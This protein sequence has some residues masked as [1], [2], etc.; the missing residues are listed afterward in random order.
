MHERDLSSLVWIL[1]GAAVM[2]AA[3]LETWFKLL[4]PEKVLMAYG[5]T[6]NFGLTVLRGDE[7]LEHRG[8]TGRG[9]R[10]T[11]IKILDAEGKAAR[12]AMM[13]E[14]HAA[15]GG[16]VVAI[17]DGANDVPMLEAADVSIAFHAKPIV[18]A[19]AT[20]AIDHCGLDA[21][22]NLFA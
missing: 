16:I 3:L 19:R 12:L 10:D 9:F 5:M 4:S 11:E 20:H 22:L 8:S 14:L 2:P 1:Q 7:W 17:G 15:D 18:R 21:A 13:R 6:E